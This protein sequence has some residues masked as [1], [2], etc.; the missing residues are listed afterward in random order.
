MNEKDTSPAVKDEVGTS[1]LFENDDVK[2]WDLQLAPGENH[3]MHRHTNDY[4]LIFVGD[5]QLRGLNADGSVR[6]EQTMKDGEVV[7]RVLGGE[8]D[9][10]DA[11]NISDELSRNFIIELKR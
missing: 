5:T 4:L 2:I 1:V 8:D 10:H 3:G 6:F 9:V 11:V 7:H